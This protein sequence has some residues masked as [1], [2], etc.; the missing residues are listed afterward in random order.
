[1]A[2]D[3]AHHDIQL[4][5][6][7]FFEIHLAVAPDVALQTGKDSDAQTTLLIELAHVLGEVDRSFLIETIRHRQ[8]LGM[9]GNS[10]VFVA[11]RARR[12]GH[13]FQRRAAIG[14]G[15]MHVQIAANVGKLDQLGQAASERSLDF[16]AILAQLGRNPG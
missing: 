8:S 14:L 16:A 15:G 3:A 9:I 2:V 5:Q 13:L 11:Q 1:M 6:G 12:F 10:D 4:R 7:V